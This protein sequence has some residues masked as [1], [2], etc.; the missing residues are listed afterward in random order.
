MRVKLIVFLMLF[1]VAGIGILYIQISD[2]PVNQW[3]YFRSF[4]GLRG[5]HSAPGI[6]N[7]TQSARGATISSTNATKPSSVPQVVKKLTG[8][9]TS[10]KDL[11]KTTTAVPEL[12]KAVQEEK[13]KDDWPSAVRK[14]ISKGFY[15]S[16]VVY[17]KP[18]EAFKPK[19]PPPNQPQ[20]SDQWPIFSKRH[21]AGSIPASPF[22]PNYTFRWDFDTSAFLQ[23]ADVKSQP[24]KI[25]TWMVKTRFMPHLPEPVRLRR[26]PDMPCRMSTNRAHRQQSAALIWNGQ[27]MG[28]PK[29]PPRDHPDQVYVFHNNE[30][31]EPSW[32]WPPSFRK[33]P[34]KSVFNWTMTYRSDSDIR[35]LYGYVVKRDKPSGKNYTEIVARKK[36]LAA[37]LVSH[38]GTH[39]KR[40]KYIKLLQT[41]MQVDTYGEFSAKKCPRN[42]DDS[43]FKMVS[44]DYK[45]FLGFESAFCNDYITEKLF[46]YLDTDAIVVARG[47]NQY[48]DYI[49][50][51]TFINTADFKSPKELAQ[52]LL[53]LDSHPEEYIAMLKA[54]DQYLV[55]YEDW[56]I[57]SASGAVVYM[58]YHYQSVFYCEMCR[59]L[60]DLDKYRKTYPDIVKWF[61]KENCYRPN[62]V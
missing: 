28:D 40:E 52:Y 61:D 47:S 27:I 56:P 26:C 37:W 22:H 23:R 19:A 32:I 57:R 58:H 12:K 11:K 5:S 45:F 1:V 39:G 62:D 20:T 2:T 30:P 48:K 21:F 41:Y 3:E 31:Q 54:K 9:K 13:K 24:P 25:I 55:L 36:G 15:N 33:A 38:F 14:V 60:W 16:I 42:Q 29:P 46:R 35:D 53:H 6:G 44:R 59:R 51:G 50:P 10:V 34:W 4:A 49:P 17:Q 7:S 8:G 43:C 18:E